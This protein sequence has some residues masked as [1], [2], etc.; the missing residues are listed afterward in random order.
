M[1]GSNGSNQLVTVSMAIRLVMRS[2]WRTAA[3][4][5][6]SP[7]HDGVIARDPDGLPYVPGKLLRSL[8]REACMLVAR[9]LDRGR[10]DGPWS[11]LA[12][13]LFHCRSNGTSRCLPDG[14]I[15]LS[16]QSVLE[17]RAARYPVALRAVLTHDEI[18]RRATTFIKWTADGQPSGPGSLDRGCRGSLEYAR[19]GSELWASATLRVP[20]T[21]RDHAVALLV[22][23]SWLLTRLGSDRS[24]GQHAGIC[25]VTVFAE[26]GSGHN[27]ELMSI[28]R[29]CELLRT[30]PPDWEQAACGPKQP[31]LVPVLQRRD[32][33]TPVRVPLTVT[34]ESTVAVCFA[35]A[36]GIDRSL[37]YVPG[38]CLLPHVT[39]VLRSLGIAPWELFPEVAAGRI[40]VLNATV[41]VAGQRGLPAPLAI[42]ACNERAGC[43]NLPCRLRN[44]FVDDREVADSASDILTEPIEQGYVAYVD[45][46]R[47][48]YRRVPMTIC[49]AAS[50]G[51]DDDE[52]AIGPT[53][54]GFFEAI[55]PGAGGS[56]TVL[57][58]ELVLP[59]ELA[60]R[61]Q[62][63]RTDWWQ[64]FSGPIWL[65]R[66]KQQ[67]HGAAYVS[68]DPPVDG[69]PTVPGCR[70]KR[71]AVWLVSDLLVR[72]DR[73]GY[74]ATLGGLQ[75]ALE[76]ALGV[77]LRAVKSRLRVRRHETWHTGWRLPRPSLVALRAGSCA[78]FEVTAGKVD[79]QRLAQLTIMGLGERTAEGF[80][81]VR[82]ND[83]ILTRSGRSWQ[84]TERLPSGAD[85][86]QQ[87]AR[88]SKDSDGYRFARL[89]ERE[90]WR[91]LVDRAARALAA[92]PAERR[93]VLGWQI[94]GR[95]SVPA[96]SEI[97]AFRA[98]VHRVSTFDDAA[99]VRGWLK[100]VTETPRRRRTWHAAE[101]DALKRCMAL[102]QEPATVWQVLGGKCDK[103]PR[104]T[105]DPEACLR[106]EL[107]AYAVKALIDACARAQRCEMEAGDDDGEGVS[108]R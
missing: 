55:A 101:C 3:P 70:R 99:L 78:M 91:S 10:H 103:W 30:A 106:G 8:W 74:D 58:S 41:D 44:A 17:V 1:S 92:D 102:F 107:W 11:R 90:A 61:L 40:R 86:T 93:R 36:G 76:Q 84:L 43:A 75:R 82:F 32:R 27:A 87:R 18:A 28:D 35:K 65:G 12:A 95:R 77:E 24:S 100:R 85:S 15:V 79:R 33:N 60:D 9:A 25:H 39:R 20:A 13:C 69:L 57:R 51:V 66:S 59:G 42:E 34:L 71:L 6:R 38:Y 72:N 73:L 63:A 31:L 64:A 37:D 52:Q 56:R 68:A 53:T 48:E 29:V 47:L 105:D 108:S 7:Q 81:D 96:M 49:T 54:V 94:V 50:L 22:A 5:N 46:R 88:L 67:D 98:V 62:R 19:A 26:D 4:S 80:G 104:L 83:P 23:G 45:K 2:E 21:I 16:G 89:I 14:H 97:L